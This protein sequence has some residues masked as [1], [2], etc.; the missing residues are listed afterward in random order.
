MASAAALRGFTTLVKTTEGPLLV[1]AGAV[2]AL[3]GLQILP[4]RVMYGQVEWVV[5]GAVMVAIGAIAFWRARP[6]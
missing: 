2:F 6:R 5:I 4:S 3:Q 1:L